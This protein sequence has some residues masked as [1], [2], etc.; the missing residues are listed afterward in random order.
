MI[1]RIRRGVSSH[2]E[3]RARLVGV[4]ERLREVST[5]L[6]RELEVSELGSKIQSQVASEM[7]K[8]QREYF[9]RQQLKAIQEE[10]GE[11]EGDNPEISELWERIKKAGPPQDVLT[12]GVVSLRV[13]SAFPRHHYPLLPRRRRRERRHHRTHI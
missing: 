8:T 4:E 2:H 11:S 7:E 12:D 3:R 9:L 6:G 10:L 13:P 5:I 1:G